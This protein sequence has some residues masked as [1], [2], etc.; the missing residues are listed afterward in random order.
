MD[1][2]I[3]GE[4]PD[5]KYRAFPIKKKKQSIEWMGT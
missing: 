3:A 1:Q 4:H 5:R 2:W